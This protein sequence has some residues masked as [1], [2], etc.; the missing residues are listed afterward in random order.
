MGKQKS[1]KKDL[2]PEDFNTGKKPVW[3]S[4]CGNFGILMAIRQAFA[5][6]GLNKEEIV[7]ISGIG[8]SDKYHQ[9]IDTY[10]FE[11][12]HGRILPVAMGIKLANH[13]LKLIAIGGDGDGYGIGMGHFVHAMRRNI[14]ITYI[15]CNNQIYGLTTGQASPTSDKGLITKST[16]FG[17]LEEPVNPISLAI[18]SGATYVARGFAGDVNHL[19]KLIIAGIKHNGFSLV[20]VFQPCVTFNHVNTYDWFNKKVYK[21]ENN[22]DK[23][24][25]KNKDAAL[26]KAMENKKLPIGVFYK[27]K[28]ITYEEE[29]EQIKKKP[30]IK[31]DIS[32]IRINKLMN[33]FT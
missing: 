18:V 13:N 2:K 15:V 23:H 30:L 7:I 16:P 9:Y 12:I 29:V 19:K 1:S 32:N 28:K 10:G 25:T 21:L 24:D 27:K 20:D 6:L 26:K 8:C 4:G 31:Q 5:D 14:N 3:C 17:N 22:K 11:S 33:E